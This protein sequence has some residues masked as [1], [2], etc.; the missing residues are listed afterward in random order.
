MLGVNGNS[1]TFGV[2]RLYDGQQNLKGQGIVFDSPISDELDPV[3]LTCLGCRNARK[4]F[5]GGPGAPTINELPVLGYPPSR[6]HGSRNVGVIP[7]PYRRVSCQTWR[8]DECDA[9][10]NVPV[11]IISEHLLIEG[12]RRFFRTRVRMNIH[13]TW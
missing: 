6:V 1:R 5:K 11:Q 3:S 7:E 9:R 4:V 8:P 10:C 12:A 13:Q 2:H